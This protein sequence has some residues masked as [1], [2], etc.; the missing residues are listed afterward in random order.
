MYFT[1]RVVGPEN[2]FHFLHGAGKRRREFDEREPYSFRGI[3]FGPSR[4]LAKAEKR[5]HHF[6]TFLRGD[7]R[8]LPSFADRLYVV[9]GH[10]TKGDGSVSVPPIPA[11]P[12]SVSASSLPKCC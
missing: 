9:N 11:S 7:R 4:I 3:L 6:Q 10:R 1:Y 5:P 2:P 12:V 8:K